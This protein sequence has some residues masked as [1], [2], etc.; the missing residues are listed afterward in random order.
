MLDLRKS[1]RKYVAIDYAGLNEGVVKTP[2]DNPNHPYVK[3]LKEKTIQ[4]LPDNFSR[5]APEAVTLDYFE[6]GGGMKEPIV[7]PGSMN[8]RQKFIAVNGDQPHTSNRAVEDVVH[9]WP[10]SDHQWDYVPECDRDKLG[11]VLPQDLTVRQ[12]A[13]LY[14]PQEKV[15]VIDVK[16][17]GE[18][19]SWNM[20]KWADYYESKNRK[21]IR[22]VISLEVSTS[23]L[24]SLIQRPEVVRQ[25]DLADSV[26]PPEQKAKG[27]FPKVQLYCLMSVA[28]SFTDFHIDFGGSSVFYHI[29]KGKKTFL[30]IPPKTKHLKKY[31][32]WCQS[33]AQNQTFLADQTK[34]CYRVDLSAGD[35][36]LIPAGWIH[37]VWTPEDSLVIGGNFLTRLHY[38]MQIQVAEIEKNTKVPRKF[39]HPH[40]QR[41]LWL[42]AIKYLKDDP[43]PAG[44]EEIFYEGEMYIRNIPSFQEPDAW[45]ASSKSGPENYHARYYSKPELDG[46]PDLVRYLLRTALIATGD[47]ADGVTADT[48]QRVARAIPKGHGDFIEVIK[49]F[50][51]WTA[52]K[53]GNEYIPHWA[54]PQARLA[55]GFT[56]ASEKK[57]S[58]AA[59]KRLEREAAAEARRAA[60]KRRSLRTK[61]KG[62]GSPETAE[63]P[64][65]NKALPNEEA[66]VD[67]ARILHPVSEGERLP[68]GTTS[69]SKKRK[70]SMAGLGD[71]TT[72]IAKRASMMKADNNSDLAN[73]TESSKQD[74]RGA[75]CE[76]CYG[77]RIVC[78]HQAIGL[79][80]NG[81][82]SV[83]L[84]CGTSSIKGLAGT[85]N[86][87]VNQ[88]VNSKSA[89][90][91]TYVFEQAY[92]EAHDRSKSLPMPPLTPSVSQNVTSSAS[93]EPKIDSAS[94]KRIRSTACDD[95]R[96]SKVR[97]YTFDRLNIPLINVLYSVDAFTTRTG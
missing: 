60:P 38:G 72:G 23:K 50:A 51:L 12:V 97:Y 64:D 65:P 46:L 58:V 87:L 14:G 92:T 17:Q 76:S 25:L 63:G 83:F 44:V 79:Q 67:D 40:F 43:L 8:P 3:P 1:S 77:Q 59:I 84:A 80:V 47:L 4:F 93:A 5:V 56:K 24:G 34:E 81:G 7:I 26:W 9:A 52:W 88:M 57:L 30:F 61:V 36:M 42:T 96:R 85:S 75:V 69:K 22:N 33:P 32:Q 89:L 71:L 10:A 95:C 48:R 82:S 37:A 19:G 11:M 16:S 18:A 49:R 45:G 53:R 68:T 35:T 91:D 74:P 66:C 15:E 13:E 90:S 54:Y 21:Y 41:I 70:V 39:R 6:K 2:D 28:D 31:E 29:L 78:Q 94:A 20:K 27:D 86:R 73:K 55:D 62:E